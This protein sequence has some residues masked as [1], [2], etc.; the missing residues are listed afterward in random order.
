M[1]TVVCMLRKISSQ[2][3]VYIFVV[4]SPSLSHYCPRES[5]GVLLLNATLLYMTRQ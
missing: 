1:F 3:C 2:L 5:C 4:Y